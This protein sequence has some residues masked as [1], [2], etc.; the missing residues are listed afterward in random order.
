[1]SAKILVVG[2]NS[3]VNISHATAIYGHGQQINQ[4]NTLESA[5]AMLE[6]GQIPNSILVDLKGQSAE[7]REFMLY[8]KHELGR[9]DVDV[10]FIGG[11][12]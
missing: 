9:S 1:M 10:V 5:R 6:G 7:A 11:K 4:A 3:E 8:V 2:G 12:Q